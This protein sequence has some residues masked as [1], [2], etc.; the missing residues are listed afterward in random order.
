MLIQLP[1]ATVNVDDI[2]H[3]EDNIV[4]KQ[5]VGTFL[6][7]SLLYQNLFVN[8]PN[9]KWFCSKILKDDFSVYRTPGNIIY[10]FF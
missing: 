6:A 5:Y 7:S 8:V 4:Y 1:N 10:S 9:F 3:E 2:L